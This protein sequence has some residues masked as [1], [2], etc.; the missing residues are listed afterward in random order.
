MTVAQAPAR[1]RDPLA[2]RGAGERHLER[3]WRAR[4]QAEEALELD[5]LAAVDATAHDR[6]GRLDLSRHN[7]RETTPRGGAGPAGCEAHPRAPPGPAE[8][9]GPA[10]GSP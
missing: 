6:R 4:R 5:V 9:P 7:G 1:G 8:P 10:G 2:R 3:L